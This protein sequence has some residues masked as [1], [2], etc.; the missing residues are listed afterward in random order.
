VAQAAAAPTRGRTPALVHTALLA[1]VVLLVATVA[2]VVRAPSPPSIQEFAPQAV[3][4]IK[5]APNN[6]S[7]Q[8]GNGGNGN[9]FDPAHCQ[10]VNNR[11]STTPT[12]GATPP[13]TGPVIDK[14]RVHQCVGNPP[15]QIE[16]YQSPP[17]VAYW[18]GDN[19]GATW[20]GVT[21]TTITVAYPSAVFGVPPQVTDIIAFV[22]SRFEMYG[23]QI[24]LASYSPA[25]VYSSL[26]PT[27]M[28]SAAVQVDQELHAFA[29][30]GFAAYQAL[31]QD[32][33]YYDEL[34]RRQ[35]LSV[36]ADDT[37]RTEKDNF[38]NPAFEGYEWSFQPG[39]D[40]LERHNVQFICKSLAGKPP[41]YA[42]TPIT[43]GAGSLQVPT[44]RKFGIAQQVQYSS[45]LDISALKQGLKGCGVDVVVKQFEPTESDQQQ[46]S[47]D[48]SFASDGVTSVICVCHGWALSGLQKNASTVQYQPEWLPIGNAASV[49]DGN[50]NPG[51][52]PYTQDNHTISIYGPNKMLPVTQ[53]PYFWAVKAMNPSGEDAGSQVG[54]TNGDLDWIKFYES[55][56]LLASGIQ[57]AGPRLTPA[58]F[59]QGLMAAQFPNPHAGEAPYYQATVGFGPGDHTMISDIA[60]GYYDRS[61]QS[62][63]TGKPGT[64]CLYKQGVRYPVGGWPAIPATALHPGGGRPPTEPCP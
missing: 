63:E 48:A 38:D 3:K 8:F 47:L 4:Q 13:A 39:L 41:G 49:D 52:S 33:Y 15:R 42:G 21:G 32:S 35:I 34:A 44:V 53:E 43:P 55:A 45:A 40:E 57:M 62:S 23:R 30:F 64:F 25:N 50:L 58:T 14:A 26:N 18:K 20:K 2:L 59:R 29:S 7:S 11:P 1:A 31:G 51:N 37:F 22:N 46:Q 61:V 24:K 5:Q 27:T 16:D 6:Q 12:T 28:H 56:L 54:A 36:T 60:V 19:G 9:C 10:G 17:C